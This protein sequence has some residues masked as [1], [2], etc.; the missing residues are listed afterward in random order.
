[1]TYLGKVEAEQTIIHDGYKFVVEPALNFALEFD[2]TGDNV[3]LSNPSIFQFEGNESFSF[4]L[5]VKSSSTTRTLLGNLDTGLSR[6]W[7]ILLNGSGELEVQLRNSASLSI[8]VPSVT[9]INNGEWHNVIVT[10]SGSESASGV[11]VY[12]DGVSDADTATDDDLGSNTMVSTQDTFIASRNNSTQLL[13]GS[14]HNVAIYDTELSSSEV[15]ALYNGGAVTNIKALT[16]GSNLIGWWGLDAPGE[17]F[18]IIDKSV[19]GN[20]GTLG[21]NPEYRVR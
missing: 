15:A 14:M 7:E 19:S 13:V 16:S 10:Y 17:T 12:I 9:A 20:N 21:G 4:Y 1:M 5:W 8:T 6:G 11:K 18:T 2:G 3:D